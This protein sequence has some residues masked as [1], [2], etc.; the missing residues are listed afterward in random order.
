MALPELFP[1]LREVN[2]PPDQGRHCYFRRSL[3]EV[4]SDGHPHP[5]RGWIITGNATWSNVQHFTEKGY[6]RLPHYGTFVIDTA[7]PRGT[8][9]AIDTRGVPWNSALEP[10]KQIL[11]MGGAK[12]FPVSQI[13][14][15]HWD[16]HPPYRGV[17]FP[18][19]RG[20]EVTNYQCPECT[21]G[22]FSGLTPRA[23][24]ELLRQHLTSRID[25]RHEYRPEDIRE[26]GRAL[27]IDFYTRNLS[28]EILTYAKS[29]P[30]SL[31]PGKEVV[32]LDEPESIYIEAFRCERCG[33]WAPL[34]GNKG[35]RN[36]LRL[37]QRHCKGPVAQPEEEALAAV[38]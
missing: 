20:V 31:E 28:R 15:M 10:W 36:A 32:N 12:E 3:N 17:A 30:E 38:S 18:Q 25:N 33:A 7:D 19:L 16:I 14:A 6:E 22:P 11:Q 13:I 23:A 9:K 4:N 27:G 34:I 2:A 8:P 21:R 37:H 29:E 24:A 35:P 5:Q 1:D 26:V